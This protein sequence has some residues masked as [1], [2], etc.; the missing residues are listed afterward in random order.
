MK[1]QILPLANLIGLSLLLTLVVSIPASRG[2]AQDAPPRPDQAQAK[3]LTD[4]EE[5]EDFLDGVMS[6]NLKD[7]NPL[8]FSYRN[9]LLLRPEQVLPLLIVALAAGALAFTVVVWRRHYW[10]VAG[11][12]HY[13]LVALAGLAFVW[14]LYYWNLLE[15]L[16]F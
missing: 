13:T 1:A 14:F 3:V 10:G 12:V 11:R 5:L 4:P 6:E 15:E 16:W 8:E 9:P 7:G 2:L